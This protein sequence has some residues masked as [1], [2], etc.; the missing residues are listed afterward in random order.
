MDSR[1][2]PYV[3]KD[4]DLERR[5]ISYLSA[6]YLPGLRQLQVSVQEGTV[7]LRGSVKSFYEKQIAIHSCQRV[8]GVRKLVDAVD[9]ARA[10]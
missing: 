5:V 8:A 10:S 6:R 3:T 4:Q 9:V 7:T 1:T 2:A